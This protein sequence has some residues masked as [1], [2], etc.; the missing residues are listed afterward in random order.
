MFGT[1]AQRALL[2]ALPCG[3]ILGVLLWESRHPAGTELIQ[4]LAAA[5]AIACVATGRRLCVL[6]GGALCIVLT[7]GPPG[8]GATGYDLETRIGT[9][10]AIITVVVACCLT[11]RRRVRL[12]HELEHTREIAV[13]SQEALLRPL[14]ARIDSLAVSAAYLSATRG[15]VVGGDLYEAI[16]T[17]RGVRIVIGDVRGHGLTVLGTV[18]TLLGCFREAAYDEVELADVLHRLERT[19]LRQLRAQGDEDEAGEEFVTLLLAE[20]RPDGTAEL[21]NCGH[22][23]P[24]RLRPGAEGPAR[25][26]PVTGEGPLPPVGLFPLP[27]PVPPPLRLRL[28]PGDALFLHTDGAEDARSSDGGFFPL[29]RALA[30]AT[31]A[32]VPAAVVDSV[33]DALL[34]HTGGQFADDVA[35]LSLCYAPGQVPEQQPTLARAADPCQALSDTA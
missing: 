5:P 8:P 14:P 1:R 16:G 6:L 7:L 10:G 34:R 30:D 28:A 17:E 12:L 32:P 27:H 18:A 11:A 33:R 13:A 20:V 21:L 25:A 9:G 3:W 19:L 31:A 23:W 4:L 22:P 26:E 35:L 24:Y 2:Y 15:A 29:P